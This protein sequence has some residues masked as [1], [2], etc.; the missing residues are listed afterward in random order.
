[1]RL[2][3]GVSVVAVVLSAALPMT[4]AGHRRACCNQY[5]APQCCAPQS[6]LVPQ[7]VTENRTVLCTEY[8]TER[9]EQK[10]TVCRPVYEQQDQVY[11]VMVP[12]QET[13]TATCT[14]YETV[15]EN[16]EQQ[17]SVM[18]PYQEQRQATRCVYETVQEQRTQ[19]V[20][21]D[22]GKWVCETVA[23]PCNPCCQRTCQRWCPNVV[24]EEV[25]YTCCRVVPRQETYN[26]TV[27]LC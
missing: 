23:D 8:R 4:D 26:Y 19:K 18:V 9:R 27:N 25:P 14:V 11:T 12:Q 22:R 1:M 17:Y 10:Y 3:V 20:C 2:G 5:A 6:M 16:V 21:V 7:L 24:E 13:R 15:T